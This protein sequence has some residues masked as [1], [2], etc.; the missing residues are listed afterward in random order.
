MHYSKQR[1]SYETY[2]VQGNF[3]HLI[4]LKKLL[5]YY[6]NLIKEKRKYLNEEK[7]LTTIEWQNYTGIRW[8]IIN[9]TTS[10]GKSHTAKRASPPKYVK[11]PKTPMLQLY[12]L[13]IIILMEHNTPN[14]C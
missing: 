13:F 10:T 3:F 14:M 2:S 6:R 8:M 5:Y 11:W 4:L 7:P 1:K 9:K 12:V